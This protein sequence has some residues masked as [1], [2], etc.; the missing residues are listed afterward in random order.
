MHD[1]QDQGLKYMS[2]WEAKIWSKAV[3][4]EA[5]EIIELQKKQSKL[6]QIIRNNP[7][8]IKKQLDEIWDKSRTKE[9]FLIISLNKARDWIKLG[10]RYN[11]VLKELLIKIDNDLPEIRDLRNMREHEIEYYQGEGR[12]QNQFIISNGHSSS[13]ATSTYVDQSGYYLGGRLKVQFAIEVF[14]YVY[15]IVS[16]EL[17]HFLVVD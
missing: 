8:T 11:A 10:T 9:Y 6:I 17:E 4:D 3:L 14:T 13:D 12:K 5:K 1:T 15:P 2:L 7:V 16:S